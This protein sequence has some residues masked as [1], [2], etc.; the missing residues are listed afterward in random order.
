M[1]TVSTATDGPE[2]VGEP[3]YSPPRIAAGAGVVGAAFA[4][5]ML[6]SG[7]FLAFVPAGLA[8]G[9]LVV[10]I[11]SGRRLLVTLGAALLFAALIL[12]G[13]DR[14]QP[15]LLLLAGVGVVLAHDGGQYAVTLG[16]QL[17]G[18]ADTARAELVHV[19]ATATV[20]SA[21]AG[22]ASVAFRVGTGG[23][24]A[25]ALVTLLLATVLLV[26]ALLR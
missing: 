11:S 16:E 7:S 6:A 5:L 9:V 20:A 13:I 12:A 19:G 2:P 23:Q 15:P 22:I 1:V 18:D 21:A 4:M 3:E 26:W 17:G 8:V 24:P 14:I 10:G 25:T